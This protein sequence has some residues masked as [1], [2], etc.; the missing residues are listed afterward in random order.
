MSLVLSVYSK[1]AFKEF[2]LPS[3]NNADYEL[4]LRKD[5]FHLLEDVVLQMD[6]IE[7][8]WKIGGNIKYSIRKNKQNYS[9][10]PLQNMDVLLI[11]TVN[12]EQISII[13]K[14][15]TSA[16]HSY[17]KYNIQNADAIFIGK[18]N[19]NDIVYNFLNMVSKKHAVI[20]RTNSG[21]KIENLSL[22]GIYVNSIRVDTEKELEFGDYINIMGLHMIYLNRILTIDLQANDIKVDEKKLSVYTEL[23]ERLN[24]SG[25]IHTRQE[26]KILFHRAP[27][28]YVKLDEERVEIEGPP[29]RVVTRAQPLLLTI[30]PSVTMALPML[31]GCIMMIYA[32]QSSGG[33]SSLYMYSGLV[34]SVSSALIGVIW[35]LVNIRYQ[36]NEE[37]MQEQH[38][39][40]AY[41]QYLVEKT[42]QIKEKY[43]HTSKMLEETYHSAEQCLNYN[44]KEGNLWN[45]NRTHED[46]IAH[47]L[48]IGD[49]P[50]QVSIDIPKKKFRLYED[51]LAVKPEFIKDNYEKLYGVPVT[52]DLAKHQLIGVVGGTAKQGAIQVARALSVQIAANNCYTDVKLGYIYNKN[53]IEDING[54]AFA[55]WLPHVWSE[56]KKT[57][58]IASSKEDASDVFYELTK[59]FRTRS[60]MTEQQKEGI[61]KP[62]YIIFISDLS[63]LEG[64]L[65][66]KYIFEKQESYGLTAILL[67]EHYEELPNSCEFIIRN[68]ESFQGMYD[69]Y[70][71]DNER[72]KI[73]FDHVHEDSLDM[74]ARRLAGIQVLEMEEGGEIPN[75]LTFFEMFGVNH[76]E[77]LPVKELWAKNRIYENIK[78]IIGRKAGDVPCYLDVHEKYHGPHGL[79]AGTTGSGKSET[80]QTYMMSLAV[81]YSPDDI[82]FFIIDYKGG[83][84]A[85][86]FEGLPH[87]IGQIS[88]LSGNQVKRAM[89]SIKSEN[90]RRQRVFN[91]NGVNNINAYTKLYKS[92][93]AA[94]PV[95]HLFIIIDEFAEL[96]REE[97]DFMKELI[98]VA[99]VGRSLGVHLIL[100]TQKPSGTVDDNIWSNSKFRLC[101][102]VQDKQDSNDMLHKPDAAYITQAGRCYLQV[103]SDEV[104]ELFQSGY[105]GAAYNKNTVDDKSDIAKM[106]TLA[107]KVEMTGN[108]VKTSRKKKQQHT[109]L[110]S[111]AEVLKESLKE[112]GMSL[113][114]CILEKDKMQGLV[115]IMYRKMTEH[116][117]EYGEN[118]YNT[119]RL[120]DF[121]R[122]YSQLQENS[123]VSLAEAIMRQ[124]LEQ[125]LKLPEQKERT[126]LEA[127]KEHLAQVAYENGYNYDLQLWMPVLPEEIFLYSFEE[128]RMN[129]FSGMGWKEQNGIGE[130]NII[131]GKVD[132]PEN[133][134]QM[135]LNLDFAQSGHVAICGSIV[136]G[137]STMMQTMIYALIQK[138]TPGVVNIYG[139]DFSS[140]M[141]SAFEEAPH[142][143]GVMYE[144]DLDKIAKFFNLLENILQ[145]RKKLFRGGNYSQYIQ[146][147]GQSMPAILIFIDN[148]SSFKEKTEEVYEEF[149]VR[150][151]KEGVNHGIY[152]IVSGAG[153][154]MN[155]ITQRVGE[156]MNTV[157]CLSLQDR[158]AYADMLHNNQF[159]VLP[160]SGVKGRGLASIGGRILEYQ[161][162]LALEAENDY[163]RMERIREQCVQMAERWD[164]KCARKI[165]EIPEKPIWSEFE[166]L[167]EMEQLVQSKDY[168]P[169]G[170]DAA[171]ASVYGIPL[172]DTYCYLIWGAARTGKTNYLKVCI[173]SA[174]KK[175]GHVCII[176]DPQK[177]LKAYE[178]AVD[179]SYVCTEEEI[180][181][182]FKELLPEFKRRNQLKNQMLSD[183]A[184][185]SEIFVRMS[186]EIPYFIFI[187]DL[188]WFVPFIY[189]SEMDMRGFL[190]NIIAKGRLHNIYFISDLSL[191]NR[192]LVSGYAIYESFANYKTGIHLGGYLANNPVM[193]FDY[194]PFMEQN[195]TEKIGVG[196]IPGVM[197]DQATKK[198]VIP[199][200][201][202]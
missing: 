140:K 100:A 77:E 129:A 201:R 189:N 30:G 58:F 51:E 195:K 181:G 130:L 106:I 164:G 19:E 182:F 145:E 4:V 198:V 114:D 185:E 127:V 55:K 7:E 200:A 92:G 71:R 32:S 18:S 170:Y 69:I 123:S 169:V 68:D 188:S 196:Q 75:S 132:D 28:T 14:E 122:L 95:P 33:A 20:R 43:E 192:E 60:E 67:A 115:H 157:L 177:N 134:A 136:C 174:M 154:G 150:L 146:V 178:N 119:E 104:Y 187:S 64:E 80:L 93:E 91:E 133:Q 152:L 54:F 155:E 138:Y 62:Y 8:E 49:I 79:V 76:P 111:L 10:E 199:L 148:Y 36:K 56:D 116:Q 105:S 13:V 156:N 99:Q 78:G 126:Q 98:S 83:G 190:E 171:N 57:R 101:L 1:K 131:L 31:L 16:F 180:F 73:L 6:I 175:L 144:S 90:K 26:G 24:E 82:G 21:Y 168:L 118:L 85:N 89:I 165:P 137:K 172:Y 46:F 50:F 113:E 109:W 184:E 94:L 186:E 22:N 48:G 161:T 166:Q 70:E 35:A 44:E 162:A 12:Q 97:P 135:P 15:K 142:V 183:D 124:A 63:L 47:R 87:M 197:D 25:S 147:H 176:D 3:I 112:S 163:Q 110:E 153:F 11:Q 59:I 9:G 141:M 158:Y 159:D 42:N 72:M 41:G 173:Q 179:V 65:F 128:F 191:E 84:M 107:G 151:S 27:R 52:L 120:C 81:N 29:E 74:F 37:K 66:S 86:L 121:I 202:R 160:E 40:E 61:P 96:K 88:N 45:R 17:R 125:K 38:R 53:K 143:G 39:F 193:N 167:E 23:K 117:L 108:K 139:L 34:M 5:Y 102:R 103:G 149:M 194:I 2:L